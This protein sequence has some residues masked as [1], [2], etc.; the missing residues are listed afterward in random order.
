ML[1]LLYNMKLKVKTRKNYGAGQIH[2]RYDPTN[3]FFNLTFHESEIDKIIDEC[4]KVK[5]QEIK[6]IREHS[7]TQ[8]S[9]KKAEK[10]ES[11]SKP[12]PELTESQKIKIKK[13]KEDFAKIGIYTKENMYTDIGVHNGRR[14]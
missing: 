5:E 12:K 13:I 8:K 2:C 14:K 10:H 1:L 6:K 7:K 11:K 4:M 3:N 9:L